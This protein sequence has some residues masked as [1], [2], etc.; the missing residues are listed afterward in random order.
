MLESLSLA[1]SFQLSDTNGELVSLKSFRGKENVVLVFNRGLAC[2]FC[3]QYMHSLRR[4][5]DGFTERHAVILVVAPDHPDA[6]SDYWLR[7]EIP[8]RGLADPDH[9]VASLYKQE[10]AFGRGRMPLV[11][12]VSWD[13]RIRYRHDSSS[14][15]DLPSSAILFDVLDRIN[16]ESPA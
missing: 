8:M 4:E 6:L 10:V 3:R 2:A 11:V 1:P 16:R 15:A 9:Q 7:E 13:G 5:L 12:I 14:E